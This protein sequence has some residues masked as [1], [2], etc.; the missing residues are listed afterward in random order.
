MK[1]KG[2]THET[3][4]LVFWCHGVPLS[5]VSNFSKEQTKGEIW[6]KLKEAYCHLQV[7]EPYSPWQQAAEDC[8]HKLKRGS[9]QKMIKIRSLKCLWDHCFD[10]EAYVCSCTSNDIS[11]TAG[12]VP[13]TIMTGNTANIS[14]IVEF[15]LYDWV[16]F[17]GTCHWHRI[18][19]DGQG[20]QIKWCVCLQVYPV[21]SH[22][23][24]AQ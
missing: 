20:P 8:I 17:S 2:D 16:M 11:M 12:Q 5:L 24:G 18:S 9:S 21:T 19:T 4:S 22:W 7:N 6:C 1:R 10:L 15:G 13:E 3:L 14:H 23:W